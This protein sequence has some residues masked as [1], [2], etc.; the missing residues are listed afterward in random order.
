MNETDCC[1]GQPG[2]VPLLLLPPADHSSQ[3]RTC[4]RAHTALLTAPTQ[5][6]GHRQCT[7]TPALTGTCV[8]AGQLAPLWS[9]LGLLHFSPCHSLPSLHPRG[10]S[11]PHLT[12]LPWAPKCLLYLLEKKRSSQFPGSLEVCLGRH[13][14]RGGTR[15]VSRCLARMPPNAA[16]FRARVPGVGGGS[17]GRDSA[18]WW[19]V[20]LRAICEGGWAGCWRAC[21]QAGVHA[22]WGV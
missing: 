19:G 21:N 14:G 2:R 10:P 22:C 4:T 12:T 6:Q 18:M 1:L 17:G 7:R 13:L 16:A 9:Q 3:T 5:R 8:R 15:L 11:P 20:V